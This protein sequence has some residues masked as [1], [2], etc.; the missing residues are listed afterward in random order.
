MTENALQLA[1]RYYRALPIDRPGYETGHPV[2]A[3][4]QDSPSGHALLEHR[5]P[6]RSARGRQLLRRHGLAP[7]NAGGRAHHGRGHPPSHGRGPRDWDAG[8]PRRDGLDGPPVS[9]HRVA[10]FGRVG[11]R[12]PTPARDARTSPRRRLHG[13]FATGADAARRNRLP[14][15]GTNLSFSTPTCWTNTCAV[16]AWIRSSTW[17]SQPTCACS[18]PRGE[19][20]PCWLAAIAAW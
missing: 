18:A 5:L 11:I 15:W 9:P 2:A 14:G 4:G 17:D 20:G 8:L 7:V 13:A 10:A 12:A 19:R 16:A 3:S 6:R 1:A